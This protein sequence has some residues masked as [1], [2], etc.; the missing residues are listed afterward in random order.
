MKIFATPARTLAF[1]VIIATLGLAIW[2]QLDVVS[3]QRFLENLKQAVVT[4]LLYITVIVGAIIGV[5][6]SLRK[7]FPKKDKK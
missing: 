3:A 4:V 2:A 6:V 1:V 5:K 7:A